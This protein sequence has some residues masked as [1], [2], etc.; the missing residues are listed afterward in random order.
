MK[1]LF[2]QTM[3]III[4]HFLQTRRNKIY[5]NC[6]ILYTCTQLIVIINEFQLEFNF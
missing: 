6:Y 5:F 2:F 1:L 3:Q 4:K